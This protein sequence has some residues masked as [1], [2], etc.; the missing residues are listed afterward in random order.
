MATRFERHH[1][2]GCTQFAQLTDRLTIQAAFPALAR[3]TQPGAAC[4]RGG[5]FAPFGKNLQSID[6]G[7]DQTIADPAAETTAVRQQMQG[8]EQAGLAGT[9]IASNQIHAWRRTQF[10]LSKTADAGHLQAGYVHVG[11]GCKCG[12]SR[13]HRHKR[14]RP[15]KPG[16]FVCFTWNRSMTVSISIKDGAA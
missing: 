10:N 7:A 12:D 2:Q 15:G 9:V 8:F 13:F 4:T 6:T 5:V 14:I 3:M 1:R 16:R 11:P